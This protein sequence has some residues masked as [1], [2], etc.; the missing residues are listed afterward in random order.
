MAMLASIMA[1]EYETAG[2]TWLRNRAD[3]CKSIYEEEGEERGGRSNAQKK[4]TS[5]TGRLSVRSDVR[6]STC[7]RHCD[8]CPKLGP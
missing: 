5:L 2:D 1:D 7:D 8:V 6:V 4:M 3:G